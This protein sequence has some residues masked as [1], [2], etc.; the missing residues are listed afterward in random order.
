MLVKS[1]IRVIIPGR[2]YRCDSDQTIAR[3]LDQVEGLVIDRGSHLG[4]LKWI[5]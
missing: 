5:L 2:T 1:L 3:F 4:H